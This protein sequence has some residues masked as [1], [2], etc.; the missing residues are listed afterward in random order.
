M[1][2]KNNNDIYKKILIDDLKARY[3]QKIS[4]LSRLLLAG[5]VLTKYPEQAEKEAWFGGLN[6]TSLVDCPNK[7][8]DILI[9]S[10]IIDGFA[11]KRK[12]TDVNY[13]GVGQHIA[14][15][16]LD[17]FPEFEDVLLTKTDFEL[18]GKEALRR[19]RGT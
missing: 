8:T 17:A 2:K 5:L 11:K 7:D 4:E 13:R 3:N 12:T 18:L 14:N 15:G 9:L 10:R 6:L 1:K 16:V 19:T